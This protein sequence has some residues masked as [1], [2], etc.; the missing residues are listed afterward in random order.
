MAILRYDEAVASSTARTRPRT[1][2]RPCGGSGAERLLPAYVRFS[3]ETGSGK[4]ET[5]RTALSRQDDHGEPDVGDGAAGERDEVL[6]ARA[7][8]AMQSRSPVRKMQPQR[9]STRCSRGSRTAVKS[10]GPRDARTRPW[11]TS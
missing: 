8:G 3:E 11:T 5:V 9:L 2:R 1:H 6:G 10:S 7:R 4:P